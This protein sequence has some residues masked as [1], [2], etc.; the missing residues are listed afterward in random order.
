MLE[1]RVISEASFTFVSIREFM[2]VNRA[3]FQIQGFYIS[4][5]FIFQ[6]SYSYFQ[7]CDNDEPGK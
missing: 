5:S 4:T 6:V 3:C 1:F 7:I 2:V